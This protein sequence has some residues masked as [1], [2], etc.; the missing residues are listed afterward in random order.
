[1]AWA[2]AGAIDAGGCVVV[3]GCGAV[4]G[5]RAVVESCA[6]T[7]ITSAKLRAKTSRTDF[8]T[9]SFKV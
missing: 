7:G 1:M 8:T 2:D 5:G 6:A 3:A 9:A 4:T